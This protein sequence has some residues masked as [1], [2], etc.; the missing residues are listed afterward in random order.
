MRK[1]FSYLILLLIMTTAT[2]VNAQVV[3]STKVEVIAGKKYYI[4]TIKRGESVSQISKAYS[5]TKEEIFNANPGSDKSII[6]GETLKV[7][8][9]FTSDPVRTDVTF[10]M[11]TIVK[12]ESVSIIAEKYKVKIAD[13]YEANPGSEKKIR[14]GDILKIPQKK[15]IVNIVIPVKT[16]TAKKIDSLKIGRPIS[17]DTIYH[18]VKKWETLFQISKKY[19]VTV[20]DLILWNPGCDKP[21]AEG[22][23]LVIPVKKNTNPNVIIENVVEDKGDCGKP[24][25]KNS[26]NVV[27]LIPFYLRDAHAIKMPEV[28]KDIYPQ[29]FKSFTFIEFYQGALMALDSMKR[30]GMNLNVSVFDTDDDTLKILKLLDKPEISNADIIIGPFY[31]KHVTVLLNKLKGKNTKVIS[32]LSSDSRNMMNPNLI[33]LNPSMEVQMGIIANYVSDSVSTSKFILVYQDTQAD[34][35][36]QAQLF[37]DSLK[38]KS[39]DAQIVEIAYNKVGMAG[40]DKEL[41]KKLKNVVYVFSEGQVFVGNMLTNL[42]KKTE[43]YKIK[44]FGMPAWRNYNNVESEYL[45]KLN[46][47]LLSQTFIDYTND[48]VIRF[49]K[50]YR[51]KYLSEPDKY[52][53]QGF[54]CTLFFLKALKEYG[55]SFAPCMNKLEFAPL[56][57]RFRFEKSGNG[58]WENKEINIYQY[59]DYKLQRVN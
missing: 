23:V 52:A 9:V 15:E 40:L 44:L 17:K 16:D 36:K 11:H 31:E 38:K 34:Q 26:Y 7:P 6:A 46:T 58:A 45:V 39:P 14:A 42:S 28:D 18:V 20:P 49:V 37:R 56:V 54:D 47:H 12:G 29:S 35:I 22:R 24:T 30:S 53:F 8:F 33:K 48:A 57:S 27:M 4:H 50:Q 19:D 2:F 5:V 25:L 41:T 10:I 55:L 3:K 43:D 13:I 21:L 32:P 1:Y 51:N 59:F